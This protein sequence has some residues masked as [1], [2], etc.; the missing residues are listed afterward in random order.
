VEA[1]TELM[2]MVVGCLT[3]RTQETWSVVFHQHIT[4]DTMEESEQLHRYCGIA[5]PYWLFPWLKYWCLSHPSRSTTLRLAT[6][7]CGPVFCCEAPLA[8]RGGHRQRLGRS[9]KLAQKINTLGETL[10]AE[11]R[12]H[13][14]AQTKDV[15]RV[16]ARYC[17]SCLFC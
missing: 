15:F 2:S 9:Q 1:D 3:L 11:Q 7:F 8:Y 12:E 4:L 5:K 14:A 16:S 17:C 6:P 10:T 13:A